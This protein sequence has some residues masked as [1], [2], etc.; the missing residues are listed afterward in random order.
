MALGGFFTRLKDGLARSTQKLTTGISAADRAQ[1][2]R[3]DQQAAEIERLRAAPPVTA[4]PTDLRTLVQARA[5]AA[6]LARALVRID[7]Q[8]ADRVV[9]VFGAVACASSA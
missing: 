8:D 6:G 3:V 7:A 4:S 1:T 5:G 2:I 9:T